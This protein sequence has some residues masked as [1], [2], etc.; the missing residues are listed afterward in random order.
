MVGGGGVWRVLLG[1]GG[2][3]RVGCKGGLQVGRFGG[4]I[5]HPKP[6]PNLCN[7]FIRP[8]QPC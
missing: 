4:Y 7:D 8:C 1:G 5:Y 2:Y 6:N 3:G